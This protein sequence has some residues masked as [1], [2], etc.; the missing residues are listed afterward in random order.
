M[1][2]RAVLLSVERGLAFGIGPAIGGAPP[3]YPSK[4]KSVVGTGSECLC[5]LQGDLGCM[6]SV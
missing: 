6:L 4:K 5:G 3:R 1:D 2:G